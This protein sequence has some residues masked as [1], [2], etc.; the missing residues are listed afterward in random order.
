MHLVSSIIDACI[1]YVN[2]HLHPKEAKVLSLTLK[3]SHS[4]LALGVDKKQIPASTQVLEAYVKVMRTEWP[5]N[6]PQRA[7]RPGMKSFFIH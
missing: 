2:V 4:L 5:W 3:S 6:E 1:V 7:F